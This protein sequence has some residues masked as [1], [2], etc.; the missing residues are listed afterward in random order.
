MNQM[1]E[2]F[3]KSNLGAFGEHLP[4]DMDGYVHTTA[5]GWLAAPV[6]MPAADRADA[7]YMREWSEDMAQQTRDAVAAAEEKL[8]A[9]Q[10]AE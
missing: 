9:W 10:S 7:E 8:A 3:H 6:D 1:S 4:C 2:S 5:A